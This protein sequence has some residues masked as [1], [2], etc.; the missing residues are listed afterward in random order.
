MHKEETTIILYPTGEK[1]KFKKGE[2]VAEILS[3]HAGITLDQP[4]G[5]RGT[6]GKCRI[7]T[8]DATSSPSESELKFISKEELS[9]GIRLACQC[10]AENDM[11][12]SLDEDIKKSKHQ[13]L[14]SAQQKW[15]NIA[16]EVRAI[17]IN[18]MD[19]D[20]ERNFSSKIEALNA[21]TD[22]AMDNLSLDQ[23]RIFATADTF[24]LYRV[25]A[26]NN[27]IIAL[28]KKEHSSDILLGAGIDI[29]TTSIVVYLFDLITGT[30]IGTAS[31]INPQT[32]F[33]GD[34]ISRI[35]FSDQDPGNLTLLH[36]VLIEGINNL[37][38]Q[39]AEENAISCEDIYH[40]AICGNP[41]MEHLF[42][43]ISPTEIGR[44]P[45]QPVF[46]FAPVFKAK[47]LLLNVN[48]YAKVDLIPNI[49]GY[50][51]GDIVAGIYYA[52]IMHSEKI[53]LLIDIG[54]NNEM[55]LG[56]KKFL[57]SCSAA[58]GPALEGARIGCGM[59][60]APGAIDYV[61]LSD[62]KISIRT[63][64][65][66]PP[67]GICGSGLIDLVA[68]MLKAG[69]IE[70]SGKMT[71]PS[72]LSRSDLAS[73]IK[74]SEKNGLEFYLCRQGEMDSTT[75]ITI[76]QRDIRET[77]LAKSAICVG[78]SKM[79][80]LASLNLE[81][82]DQVFLAGAF[83][84]YIDKHNAIAIGLLPRIEPDRIITLGNTAGL[85]A[86]SRILLKD[87]YEEMQRIVEVTEHVDLAMQPDFQDMFIKNL[88]FKK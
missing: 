77:Q 18:Y 37:F 69:M 79:L 13:I 5:G 73:R 1:L 88:S 46:R 41:T 57:L 23:L 7:K 9:Q 80:A 44:T 48:P 26:S 42:L 76:S 21:K 50:I 19:S 66:Q 52:G 8:E 14:E 62:D 64:G 71:D 33:G 60:A 72:K 63:I 68:E 30:E 35:S 83:G 10:K 58:A 65:N 2:T 85:G 74:K 31:S 17:N 12:I 43:G 59:R 4:C 38:K 84:N 6:C 28:D 82:I 67:I 51:G 11:E 56:N 55:V 53:S 39:L 54:T 34:V 40:I 70:D 87:S 16:P 47:D 61:S 49:S 78:I 86:C 3:S 15:V 24:P 27:K 32:R 22:V 29:G 20:E 75:D 81:Q 25:I 45:F 36:K